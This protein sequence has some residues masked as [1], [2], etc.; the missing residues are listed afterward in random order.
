METRFSY[1]YIYIYYYIY[2]LCWS[3]SSGWGGHTINLAN[4]FFCHLSDQDPFWTHCV[5]LEKEQYQENENTSQYEFFKSCVQ[6][7]L[8]IPGVKGSLILV[9]AVNW[10]DLFNF[11][12]GTH[13][14][15]VEFEPITQL[16]RDGQSR[17]AVM[18]LR[19]YSVFVR[20]TKW[21]IL[22]VSGSALDSGVGWPVNQKLT[23]NM[24]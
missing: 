23:P 10:F 15:R 9:G 19:E 7:F 17:C 13:K 2:I 14:P 12:G 18:Q 4:I 8:E 11:W 24:P 6:S 1:I 21:Y 3:L 16:R 22:G 5:K 20:V